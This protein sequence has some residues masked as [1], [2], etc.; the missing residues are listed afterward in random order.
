MKKI[1]V[2]L[3]TWEKGRG[4]IKEI[5]S[6]FN[7][8][9]DEREETAKIETDQFSAGCAFDTREFASI[10]IKLKDESLVEQFNTILAKYQ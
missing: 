5:S 8:R 9:I 2:K 10:L 3:E 6:T 1:R 7:V 4:F